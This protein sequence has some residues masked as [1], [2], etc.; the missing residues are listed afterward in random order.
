MRV[1]YLASTYDETNGWGRLAARFLKELRVHNGA[2]AVVA[3]EASAFRSIEIGPRQPLQALRDALIFRRMFAGTDVIYAATEPMA[4]LG[5]ILSRL[6]KKP[7]IIAVAGTFADL[8][9]YPRTVR[10]LYRRAFRAAAAVTV[11]SRYTGEVLKR[12][13]PD[14]EPVIVPGGF[15]A[16]AEAIPR[17][18]LHRPPRLLTV[19]YLKPRKGYHT[20]VEALGLVRQRGQTFRADLVGRKD[21]GEYVASLERKISERGMSGDV[22][23]R[24]M[25][26]Q[27]ELD[28]A[29]AEAD[30]FVLPSEHSGSAFEGLGLVFLEALARGIPVIGT[31]DSGATDIIED[32]KNGRLVPPGDPN[33]LAAAVIAVI[34][35]ETAWKQMAAAAPASVE[36]FRWSD[37]GERLQAVLVG[38][39]T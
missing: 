38:S 7:L 31:L 37:V 32:G 24:G 1:A 14:I 29:Y 8:S 10:W 6:L 5:Y 3:P 35:D 22:R 23:L 33:A 4:L 18:A 28:A 9:V 13:L 27:D 2:E 34:S 36:R 30:L 19:G 26:S 39:V 11:L 16:P 25:I 12:S 17:E 20:L 15:D 21:M